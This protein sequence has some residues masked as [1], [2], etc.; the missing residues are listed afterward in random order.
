VDEWVAGLYGLGPRDLQVISDTLEFNLPFAEN[1]RNAQEVPTAAD[2]ERFCSLL[3]KELLPWGER[4]GTTLVVRPFSELAI[5]PWQSI[6]I[7]RK[8]AKVSEAA[9]AQDWEGLLRAADEAAAAEVLLRNGNNGLLIGRLAQ[10]RYWSKTQARLLA[11]R[12][13]WSHLDLLKGHVEA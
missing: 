7:R 9:P 11:Q 12:I 2:R 13:I 10:K 1:K 8:D 6:E 4:F 5:S 3:A